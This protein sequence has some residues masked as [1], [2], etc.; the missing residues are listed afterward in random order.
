MYSKKFRNKRIHVTYYAREENLGCQCV[1][2]HT[3]IVL[4][5]EIF[6]ERKDMVTYDYARE[7]ENEFKLPPLPDGHYEF[8]T[9]SG[10]MP[11]WEPASV[12]DELKSQLQY[13][14]LSQDTLS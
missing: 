10:D 14:S 2:T 12:E 1:L 6:Q 4:Y 7:E 8:D 5:S 11:F 3:C 13:L 9:G